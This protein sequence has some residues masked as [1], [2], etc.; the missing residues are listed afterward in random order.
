M[1]VRRSSLLTG[2]FLTALSTLTLEIL[3]TRLLSVITWYHLSFF[4]ISTAMFGMTAGVGSFLSDRLDLESS[5]RW[6]RRM[7]RSAAHP[8][9]A[10]G[11]HLENLPIAEAHLDGVVLVQEHQVVDAPLAKALADLGGDR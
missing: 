8:R 4:A 9:G 7:G 1:E 3:D 10:P 5:P 11:R 6:L 2:L